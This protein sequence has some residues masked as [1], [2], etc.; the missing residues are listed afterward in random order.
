MSMNPTSQ[1][2]IVTG[3]TGFI[4]G[5]LVNLLLEKGFIVI[6][7]SRKTFKNNAP[8]KKN[9]I[10]WCTWENIRETIQKLDVIP[11]AVVHLATAYGR[12][13]E[14]FSSVE[15]ANVVKPLK[16][17]ELCAKLGIKKFINTD[18]YF[19]KAEFD[20]QYMLPY[21]YTKK[22]F[23]NWGQLISENHPVKFLNMR[24]E[25]VYGPGDSGQKFIP[26]ILDALVR[27]ER[28]VECTDCKQKRD[29]VYIDDVIS[30]YLTVIITP[31]ENLESYAEFQVG[32]GKS[33]PLYT[34]IEHLKKHLNNKET[35]ILYGSMPTRKN[36]ILNSYAK[37]ES[38]IALGWE[39]KH[40]YQR[41]I[42]KLVN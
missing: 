36:E 14:S 18:S 5:H 12:N 40:T 2:I 37:N 27:N 34:F 42:E 29:L 21:I 22:S 39:A 6:A 31:Y 19:S 11:H 8:Y 24:L 4:G 9:K 15:D 26:F 13:N 20:Y 33:I 30:A 41:G 17:L 32:T 1:T 16:L 23:N 38:L 10:V 7:L 25:H 35:E 28:K 3:A